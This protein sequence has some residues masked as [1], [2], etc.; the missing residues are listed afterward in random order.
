MPARAGDVEPKRSANWRRANGIVLHELAPQTGSL[1]DAFLAAH[2]RRAGVPGTSRRRRFAAT[3]PPLGAP[4][5]TRAACT[6]AGRAAPSHRRRRA[7]GPADAR[8]P[9]MLHAIRSEWIKLRRRGRTWCSPCSASG[10]PLAD[11]V[12]DRRRSATSGSPTAPTRSAPWCSCPRYLC[13]FLSGVVG[14]LGIGQ[15]YR[16]N[17]IRVTFTV[18]ARRSR[19]LAAKLIVTT[20]F[21]LAMGLVAQLLCFGSAR[22]S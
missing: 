9:L 13:V 3:G 1:E 17:T 21:G 22:R 5:P 10:I 14:V 6:A 16:H 19:V 11:L 18:E 15:E 20:L 2:G 7:V 12:A 4:P 8:G